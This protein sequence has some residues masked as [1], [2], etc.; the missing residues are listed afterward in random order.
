MRQDHPKKKSARTSPGNQT[1]RNR[2][3]RDPHRFAPRFRQLARA[4]AEVSAAALTHEECESLLEFYVDS[5]KRGENARVLYPK[6][7]KH[8]DT[9][10]RCRMMY[11]AL[12][13]AVSPAASHDFDLPSKP[14]IELP[15]LRQSPNPLWRKQIR[16]PIAGGALGFGFTLSPRIVAGA[17]ASRKFAALRE[18]G[19]REN[20][21]TSGTLLL[22]D[23][24]ALGSR[25]VNVELRI[26]SDQPD[27]AHIEVSVVSSSPLPE[28]VS[29]KLYWNDKQYPAIVEQGH[30]SID[31]IAVSDLENA[32]VRL[33]FEA[34]LP[35]ASSAE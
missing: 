18:R 2:Y 27:R 25:N 30:A 17:L 22:F 11:D 34:G 23:S 1:T 10:A 4:V 33:E 6:V 29:V 3:L 9:C 20:T 14:E 26:G 15:F 12:S 7:F 16:S 32:Q 28:P 24:I 19:E 21:P 13:D 31:D 5:E 35:G 8:F